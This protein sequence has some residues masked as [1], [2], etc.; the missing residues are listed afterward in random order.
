MKY[1]EESQ[2]HCEKIL[3]IDSQNIDALYG[4]AMSQKG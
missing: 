1:Y 4:I 3:E 2:K